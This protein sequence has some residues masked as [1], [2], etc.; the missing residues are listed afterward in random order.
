MRLL[1]TLLLIP[2]SACVGAQRPQPIDPAA[3]R[4]DAIGFFTGRTEGTG[5][6]RK[7]FSGSRPLR[8]RGTGYREADGALV[9]DQLVEEAGSAP[10]RRQWRMRETSPGRYSGSLSDAEGPVTGEADGNRLHLRF[11][12]N[13]GLDAEQWLTL[14]ADGRVASNR[15]TVRKFG[16]TVAAVSE[17]IRKTD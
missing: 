2:L 5:T 8:V 17:T 15:M 3:P 9:L 7:I 1:L 12:M 4:F 10:R 13:G 14:S 6:L 16:I 11:R